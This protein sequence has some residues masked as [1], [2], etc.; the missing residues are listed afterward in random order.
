MQS[1]GSP[2]PGLKTTVLEYYMKTETM[3]ILFV[4]FLHSPAF[5]IL[6]HLMRKKRR[7][8]GFLIRTQVKSESSVLPKSVKEVLFKASWM[9]DDPMTSLILV[10]YRAAWFIHCDDDSNTHSIFS[11][12]ENDL[13]ISIK[14]LTSA[15]TVNTE[16]C[17][18]CKHSNLK[19]REQLSCIDMRQLHRISGIKFTVWIK[20]LTNH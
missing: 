9:H 18:G 7:T 19:Q 6:K 2:G 20:T 14:P 3:T 5:V 17:V 13:A 1:C 11:L 10:F 8:T 16:I 15:I 12:N 4:K